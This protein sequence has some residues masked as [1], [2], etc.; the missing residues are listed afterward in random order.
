MGARTKLNALHV[1]GCLAVAALVGGL[2]SS[3]AAF[4]ATFAIL[5]ASDLLLGNIR[6]RRRD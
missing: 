2:A 3:W 6:S 1:T 4:V 5:A